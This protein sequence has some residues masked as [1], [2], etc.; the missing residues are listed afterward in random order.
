[1]ATQI[2]TASALDKVK[3]KPSVPGERKVAQPKT[4]GV[5]KVKEV[6]LVKLFVVQQ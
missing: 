1:L 5:K 2:K 3:K 6:T 4:P